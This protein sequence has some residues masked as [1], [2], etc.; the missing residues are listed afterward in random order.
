[1]LIKMTKALDIKPSEIT[2]KT[3]FKY[4]RQFLKTA[5]I[6]GVGFAAG[7]IVPLSF[8]NEGFGKS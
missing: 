3:L 6:A 2:P 4:R 1:M 7:A 5:A 8:A